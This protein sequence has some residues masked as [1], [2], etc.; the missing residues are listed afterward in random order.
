M[1]SLD[2][3]RIPTINL[4][5]ISTAATKAKLRYNLR[6]AFLSVSFLYI[7]HYGVPDRVIPDLV[8]ALPRL[9]DLAPVAKNTVAL[10][11]SP[12]FL[13]YRGTGAETTAG[14][15]DRREQVEWHKTSR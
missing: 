14:K 10:E 15:V 2:F 12:H 1:K 13:G 6:N 11:N 8:E 7:S 4:S 5:R 9:F 3:K